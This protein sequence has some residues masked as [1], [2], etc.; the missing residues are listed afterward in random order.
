M[1]WLKSLYNNRWL[2]RIPFENPWV[3]SFVASFIG[4]TGMGALGLVILLISGGIPDA[5]FSSYLIL[6]SFS[7][8]ALFVVCLI[9]CML[10]FS[11]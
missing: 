10:D 8:V 3:G 5:S 9:A 6:G 11:G 7:F 4:A 1:S 2:N